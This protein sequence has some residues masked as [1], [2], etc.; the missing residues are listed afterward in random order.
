MHA[1]IAQV[2]EQIEA[3]CL[4]FGVVTLEVFG[5]AARGHDFDD[6][7]SDADFLV[8]FGSAKFEHLTSFIDFKE[9]LEATLGRA[10]DLVEREAIEESSNFIRRRRI[11]AE[12]QQIYG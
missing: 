2:R 7:R 12:A 5:S 11:L 8:S 3:L 9:A 6:A 1:S 10:V 4:N